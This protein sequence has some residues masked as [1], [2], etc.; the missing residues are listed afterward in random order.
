MN[1]ARLVATGSAVAALGIAV[2]GVQSPASAE[3]NETLKSGTGTTLRVVLYEH[4]NFGGHAI[5]YYGSGY[6]SPTTADYD[7]S[8]S[9]MPGWSYNSWN[10]Q[11]SSLRDY[12]NCDVKLYDGEGF[13]DA[14][15]GWINAGETGANLSSVWN[16]KAGSFRVS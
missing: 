3:N 12:K 15:T 13:T 16:D 8:K 5:S 2:V 11:V 9:S 10:N 1:I 6:C 7:Y 4:A 14:A